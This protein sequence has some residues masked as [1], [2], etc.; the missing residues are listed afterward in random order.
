MT[1]SV[2]LFGTQQS[3]PTATMSWPSAVQTMYGAYDRMDILL[4]VRYIA[5]GNIS[6]VTVQEEFPQS[7]WVGGLSAG[8][9]SML[10]TAK[11]TTAIS[12]IGVYG[13]FNGDASSQTGTVYTLGSSFKNTMLGKGQNK[14]I[15]INT[16]GQVTSLVVDVIGVF[17]GN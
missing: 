9:S 17:Y 11:I 1:K 6:T 10:T 15:V 16:T 12:A 14:Q 13:L 2:I 5:G 4:N 7:P 3:T 8:G